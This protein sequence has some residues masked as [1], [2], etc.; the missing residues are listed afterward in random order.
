MSLLVAVGSGRGSGQD[1]GNGNDQCGKSGTGRV[2]AI[3][4]PDFKCGQVRPCRQFAPGLGNP[5]H[6]G[7]GNSG[8]NGFDQLL[9]GTGL[10]GFPD[11]DERGRR[12]CSHVPDRP[13]GR[14]LRKTGSAV[15]HDFP[16]SRGCQCE[17]VA[18]WHFGAPQEGSQMLRRG[19]PRP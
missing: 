10:S 7:P 18:L 8:R 15:I 11:Q 19:D 4:E 1:T 6:H 12:Q 16:R 9:I 3:R 14:N 13:G 17:R 2:D 5:D